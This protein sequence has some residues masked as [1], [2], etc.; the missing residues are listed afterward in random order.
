M[1]KYVAVS[2]IPRDDTGEFKFRDGL[3]H[4][5]RTYRLWIITQQGDIHL[6]AG[7]PIPSVLSVRGSTY[8][9]NG[10][11]SHS[12]WTLKVGTAVPYEITPPMHGTVWGECGTWEEGLEALREVTKVA[13]S[14]KQF[15]TAIRRDFAAAAK[16]WDEVGSESP[17]A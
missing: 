12:V 15:E 5:G 16:R 7:E 17:L 11:W 10:K 9:R 3:A 1:A 14:R 8:T 13:V 6:F 4:A 2:V